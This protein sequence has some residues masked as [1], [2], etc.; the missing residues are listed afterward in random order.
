M[1]SQIFNNWAAKVKAAPQVFNSFEGQFWFQV[2]QDNWCFKSGSPAHLT[3][4]NSI[5]DKLGSDDLLIS[6]EAGVFSSIDKKT[7]EP[8]EAYLSG[9]LS[10]VGSAKAQLYLHRFFEELL[11]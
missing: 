4:V 11:G 2:G 5:P 8:A 7:V 9:Q 1:V 3:S 6:A 10:L